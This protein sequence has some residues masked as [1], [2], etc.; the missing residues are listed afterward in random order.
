VPELSVSVIVCTYNRR[1]YLPAAMKPLL[2][3]PGAKEIVVVVDGSSDGSFEL[4]T[5]MAADDARLKPVFIANAGKES[6]RQEGVERAS[7]DVVLLLD[8]DVVADPGLVAGHGRHH[9]RNAGLVVV[10][11]MPVVVGARR[12]P[13][14]AAT[15]LYAAE[16]EGM[17]ASYEHD[18]D[19]VLRKLWGGNVSLRRTD[20]LRVGLRS[21]YSAPYHQD[22][23]FG[24]R[25]L[26]AGLEGRF[27]RSLR[28]T[29]M[30]SR[31]IDAF[32]RD[33]RSQGAGLRQVHALHASQTGAFDHDQFERGLPRPLAA[34]VRAT[35]RPQVL[36]AS[37]S[38]LRTTALAAG[39]VRFDRGTT[40]ALKLLRRMHQ[41][42]GAL[43]GGTS[44]DF[45]PR[46]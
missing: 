29:H 18:P 8:D 31:T 15:T 45:A 35:S 46:A 43:A 13:D 17:V 1:A 10:G 44:A 3:D 30:H 28:A 9:A 12:R 41:R 27:D 23:D 36:K 38:A 39:H 42:A 32:L 4:L 19:L 14:G 11:Y 25:C 40:A 20:A 5:Q 24:L 16:Y 2:D 34:W 26:E 7:G 33:S 21:T 22:R 6:A 37:T